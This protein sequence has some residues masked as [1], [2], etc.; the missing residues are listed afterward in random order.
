MKI[1][2]INQLVSVSIELERDEALA[3]LRDPRELQ[4]K[5]REKLGDLAPV[6]LGARRNGHRN[7]HRKA[8]PKAARARGTAR[9]STKTSCPKC[10]LQF[11]ERGLGVHMARKHGTDGAPT[12]GD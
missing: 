3:A 8:A 2:T 6:T 9:A 11:E 10:G 4:S 5:L 7:G 12:V 1:T